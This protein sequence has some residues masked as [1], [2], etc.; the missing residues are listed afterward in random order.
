[1]ESDIVA[2][3]VIFRKFRDGGDVIALFPGDVGDS[4]PY[5]CNSYMHVGQDGSADPWLI[6][7]ATTPATPDEYGPLLAEL[8]RIGYEPRIIERVRY[9]HLERR[10]KLLAMIR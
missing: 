1:M 8:R 3:D 10:R 9:S 6:V 7:Q 4:S 2:V 5:T